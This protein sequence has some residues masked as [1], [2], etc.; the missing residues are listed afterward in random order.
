MQ[1]QTKSMY[2]IRAEHLGLLKEI[3]EADGELTPEME[4]AL[5]LTAEEFE[6]KAVSYGF[7]V[8]S[9]EDVEEVLD[10]EI[11]RLQALKAKA[12]KR[13]EKFKDTLDKAMKEFGFEKIQTETLTLSYRKSKPV[14]LVEDFENSFLEHVSIEIVPKDGAPENVVKLIEYFDV[15]AAPSKT[16]IGDALKAGSDVPG[17]KIIER[18]NLQI[19]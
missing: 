16:R 3:E 8:K 18:K 13:A 11:K 12:A 10:K 6:D 1:L 2:N 5:A 7:V 4:Q 15:K 19:K 14:E 17:A 9:F